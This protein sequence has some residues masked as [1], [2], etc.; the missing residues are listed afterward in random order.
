MS[1]KDTNYKREVKLSDE[2]LKRFRS[3]ED[4]TFKG[5]DEMAALIV[6]TM[7]GSPRGAAR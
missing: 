2:A 5:L 7:E 1:T 3:V 4:P 6:E